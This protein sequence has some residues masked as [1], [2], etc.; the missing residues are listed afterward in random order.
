MELG[1]IEAIRIGH[2]YQTTY[3]TLWKDARTFPEARA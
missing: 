1:T 2:E 3:G